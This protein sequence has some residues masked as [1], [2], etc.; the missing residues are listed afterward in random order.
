[1]Y[2]KEK[3]TTTICELKR[4]AHTQVNDHKNHDCH[5]NANVGPATSLQ[6]HHAVLGF[7]QAVQAG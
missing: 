4:P 6:E 2:T 5:G 3:C 1:M 7:L